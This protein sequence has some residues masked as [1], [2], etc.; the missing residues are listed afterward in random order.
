MKSAITAFYLVLF[1][2]NGAFGCDALEELPQGVP[3]TIWPDGTIYIDPTFTTPAY[4]AAAF[5]LLLQEANIV[6]RELRLPEKLPITETD[7]TYAYIVPFGYAR[8]T[9]SVGNITTKNYFYNVREGN[10][11][12]HLTIANYDQKCLAYREQ[13][14]WPL[15]RMDTNAAYQLATQWLTA[16]SMDVAGL[17]RDC[18][19]RVALSPYW[20]DV[21]TLGEVPKGPKFVP[22]YYVWWTPTQNVAGGYGG[23]SVEL[24]LPTKTLIALGVDDPKYILRKPLVFTN[25]ASLFPQTNAPVIVITNWPPTKYLSAPGPN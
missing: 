5:K 14:Q 15:D 3:R 25:L 17:N 12:S 18:E 9:K 10:K 24:F 8:T 19:V 13:Y 23:A 2:T 16:L 11:F 1:A 20:N 21:R 6:A 22:I 4:Q 7:V